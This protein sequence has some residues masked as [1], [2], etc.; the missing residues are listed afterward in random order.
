M[1]T[2]LAIVFSTIPIGICVAQDRS[3]Q[4]GLVC[5]GT[6]SDYSLASVRD[7]PVSGIY[8]Q[9]SNDRVKVQGAAGLDGTYSVIH[10]LENGIGIQI[11]SNQAF[12]GFLN[13]FSGKLSLMEKDG[14]V[15]PD[16]SFQVRQ[17]LNADCAKAHSIF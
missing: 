13:R 2:W 4:T 1:R 7:S 17:I 16:G 8:L 11:A 10:R 15:K 5:H 9:V 14:M 6:Y 12:S 3:G